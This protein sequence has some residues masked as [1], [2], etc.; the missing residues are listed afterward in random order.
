VNAVATHDGF[1]VA[2]LVAYAAPVGGGHPQRSSNG[3][4]EGPTADA[5][6][7]AVRRRRQRALLGTVLC[8]QGV[9]MIAAGDELGRTQ[10]GVADAYTLE[11]DEWG[12]PWPEADWD[13]AAWTA[14]AVALRHEH[15]V[16]RRDRWVAPVDAAVHWMSPAGVELDRHDWDHADL[17]GLQVVLREDGDGHDDPGAVLVLV[18]VHGQVSFELPRGRWRIALDAARDRPL[19]PADRPLAPARLALDGPGLVVAVAAPPE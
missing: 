1:T 13:L 12:V 5:H 16:L 15:P 18:A 19:R 10:G 11:P 7:V 6:V 4:L 17:G 14:A 3:G 8:A 9:P 2:D